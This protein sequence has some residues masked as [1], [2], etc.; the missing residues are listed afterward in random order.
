MLY[1][2]YTNMIKLIYVSLLLIIMILADKPEWYPENATE[3]EKECL[4]KF[5]ISREA[6]TDIKSIKLVDVPNMSSLLLCVAHGQNVYDPE[7]ELKAERIVYGLYRSLHLKCE[8]N[9]V[10]E[11]LDDNRDYHEDGNHDNFMY[12]LVKCIFD[13]SSEQCVLSDD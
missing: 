1:T 5:P 13:K 7:I 4:E 6:K 10:Q 3:I 9:L 8:L 2:Q 12:T 11:C